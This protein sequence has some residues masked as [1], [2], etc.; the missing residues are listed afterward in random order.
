MATKQTEARVSLTKGQFLKIFRWQQQLSLQQLAEMTG[1]SLGDL[2]N[3]EQDRLKGKTPNFE[4]LADLMG[5]GG[6]LWDRIGVDPGF[7]GTEALEITKSAARTPNSFATQINRI[8]A[9][10]ENWRHRQMQVIQRELG[11]LDA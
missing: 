6:E 11:Y 7:P 4:R 5:C 1:N 2:H 9:M 10:P 8:A 3:L